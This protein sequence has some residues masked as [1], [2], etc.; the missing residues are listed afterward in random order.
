M[1]PHFLPALALVALVFAAAGCGVVQP[2]QQDKKG[3]REVRRPAQTG[4]Y[5]SRTE[6]ASE[7]AAERENKGKAPKATPTPKPKRERPKPAGKVEDDFVTRGGF[8]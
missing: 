5:I 4:T 8:R 2:P 6:R 3:T 1:I 7:K